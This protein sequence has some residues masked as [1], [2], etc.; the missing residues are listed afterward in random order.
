M[1]SPGKARSRKVDLLDSV[2]TVCDE[3]E[4]TARQPGVSNLTVVAAAMVSKYPDSL[5]DQVAGFGM[6]GDST[7][8][9]KQRL[10]R[11]F[12]NGNRGHTNS[13][14]RKLLNS[15]G[16][17][18]SPENSEKPR[19]KFASS[20]L[21]DS[22]GCKN[23]QPIELLNGKSGGEERVYWHHSRVSSTVL[24]LCCIVQRVEF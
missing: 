6:L 12:E 23:R 5:A 22:Y 21:K 11:Q 10:V 9:L 24:T 1:P 3:I 18:A 4:K 8:R 2:R 17:E 7:A 14:K 19:K 13:M 16:G 15:I 20:F